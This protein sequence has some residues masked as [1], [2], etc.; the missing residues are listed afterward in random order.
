MPAPAAPPAPA[1]GTPSQASMRPVSKAGWQDLAQTFGI[2]VPESPAAKPQAVEPPKATP[3]SQPLSLPETPAAPASDAPVILTPLAADTY[4]FEVIEETEIEFSSYRLEGE[5]AAPL[6]A[7]EPLSDVPAAEGEEGPRRGRR[8]RRRRRGG[9]REEQGAA[10]GNEFRGGSEGQDRSPHDQPIRRATPP[11]HGNTDM[12]ED[13]LDAIEEAARR[14]DLGLPP[15]ERRPSEGRRGRHRGR[16]RG[17]Y[18]DR[19]RSRGETSHEPLPDG[20]AHGDEYDI[21]DDVVD[22]PAAA[23]R[24]YGGHETA[25]D[26]GGALDEIHDQEDAD[27]EG[28]PESLHRNIYTWEQ[29]VGTLIAKNMESRARFPGTSQPRGRG[30]GGRHRGRGR[31]RGGPREG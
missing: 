2:A 5:S 22:H 25:A 19:E 8:R 28:H 30:R 14:E 4:K 3:Y 15:L 12:D 1:Q 29:T 6:E 7:Q 27:G 17:R 11:L 21:L 9:R 26:V 10:E 23:N 13:E 24:P 16:R 31:G 18:G 20:V